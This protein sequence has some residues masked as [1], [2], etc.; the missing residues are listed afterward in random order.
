MTWWLETFTLLPLS[1][2]CPPAAGDKDCFT[3]PLTSRPIKFFLGA[4]T[5]AIP[6]KRLPHPAP[7]GVLHCPS[8]V[9][10]AIASP[11]LL[12]PPHPFSTRLAPDCPV[13]RK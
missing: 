7:H 3:G 10:L 4:T 11:F 1:T 13:S 6:G 8:P 5:K 9:T 12:P 2:P